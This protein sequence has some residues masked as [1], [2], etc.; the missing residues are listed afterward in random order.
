MNLF[1]KHERSK[2]QQ[3]RAWQGLWRFRRIIYSSLFVML[4]FSVKA[5]VFPPDLQCVVNDTLVWQIPN[6]NCGTFN[7]Y[8][9]FFSAN[10]NGP[11]QSLAIITDQNQTNFYHNNPTGQN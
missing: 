1:F 8:E 9:I 3:I 7:S 4:S 10:L 5:Q 2:C 6:N 11:Y